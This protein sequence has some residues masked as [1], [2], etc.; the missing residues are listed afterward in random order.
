MIRLHDTVFLK[1]AV[2]VGIGFICGFLQAQRQPSAPSSDPICEF[3]PVMGSADSLPDLSERYFGEPSYQ[4]A[5]LLAT[6]AH[7]SEQG[8]RF[9]RDPNQLPAG[10]YACIPNL[11][12]AGRL[13]TEYDRYLRSVNQARSPTRADISN[14][15]VAIDT[16]K[17]VKVVTWI[18]GGQ[19][20]T[21][22]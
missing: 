8:F 17:P 11:S 22:R 7:A 6:N 3:L 5:I 16:S 1:L 20:S 15:L 9:I 12:T 10:S 14:S 18:R 19:L 2:V 13:R 4:W 21:F